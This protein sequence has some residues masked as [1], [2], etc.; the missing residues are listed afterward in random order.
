MKERQLERIRSRI[1]KY[2][3]KMQDVALTYGISHPKVL[4][5]S[6]SLD[7]KVNQYMRLVKEP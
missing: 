6:M 3:S 1:E 5:V 2:R 7:I 4:K